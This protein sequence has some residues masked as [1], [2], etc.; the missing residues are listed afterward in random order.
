MPEVD[1]DERRVRVIKMMEAVGLLP[2]MINR[3]P[4]E[5]SGGQAQR[6]GIARALITEPKLIVCDEPVSALDV[7]IQAQILNLLVRAQGSVRADADLHLAQ[8]LGGAARLG[9]HHGPLPR[10]H[11]RA[12]RWRRSLRRSQAPLHAGAADRGADPRPKARAAAQYRRAAGRNSVADQPALGLHLPHPLPLRGRRSAPR[13]GRRSRPPA[14]AG[15]SPATAG[16][17]SASR[18]GSELAGTP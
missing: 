12:R 2:E 11:R 15:S 16:A 9:P 1:A 7:S 8:P 10:P 13:S 6:I 17:K 3:Y 5:F 4:H 18:A 14:R